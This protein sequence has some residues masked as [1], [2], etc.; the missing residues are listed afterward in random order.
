MR[1]TRQYM[2]GE[3]SV[4]LA[5][6]QTVTT[7]EAAGHEARSLRDAAETG[8][9]QALRSVTVCALAL[10]EGLCWDSLTRGDTV[11]FNRQAAVCAELHQ[12]GVCAGLLK[13]A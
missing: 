2:A 7:T 4:L 5:H 3:L 6:L 11:A 1:M 8:P 13:E 9:I 12:F 10:A